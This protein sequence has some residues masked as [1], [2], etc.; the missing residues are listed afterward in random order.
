MNSRYN[1]PQLA[2][3]RAVT[4]RGLG[5]KNTARTRIGESDVFVTPLGLG[6]AAL[7]NLYEPVDDAT[8]EAST[9][10][11]RKSF[12]IFLMQDSWTLDTARS[13]AP[14]VLQPEWRQRATDA[15]AP[16]RLLETGFRGRMRA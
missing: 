2:V 6:C 13:G 15:F 4:Y 8:A 16:T 3:E 10:E 14:I 1:S 11:S 7:G 5:L 9:N 12:G